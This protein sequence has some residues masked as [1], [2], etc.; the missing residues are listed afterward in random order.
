VAIALELRADMFFTFDR[1]QSKLAR[2][3]GIIVRPRSF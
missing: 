2:R 3:A 1:R